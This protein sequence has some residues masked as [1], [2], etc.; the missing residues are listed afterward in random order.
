[1]RNLEEQKKKSE[2]FGALPI[3]TQT[4][5]A[6]ESVSE[7]YK[8]SD[9]KLKVVSWNSLCLMY[10]LAPQVSSS[11]IKISRQKLRLLNLNISVVKRLHRKIRHL[12]ALL[13]FEKRL[14]EEFASSKLR[15]RSAKM[16]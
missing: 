16:I 14:I 11:N 15:L 1:M 7:S 3:F 12:S 5:L 2:Q 13:A 4:H 8:V 10:I 9:D 6:S